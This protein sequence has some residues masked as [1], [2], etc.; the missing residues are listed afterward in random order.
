LYTF[1]LVGT[2]FGIANSLLN[3]FFRIEFHETKLSLVFNTL[4]VIA[5]SFYPFKYYI[6]NGVWL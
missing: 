5:V 1:L 6:I 3:Y 2:F 4:Y